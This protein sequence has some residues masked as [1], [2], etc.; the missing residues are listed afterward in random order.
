MTDNR[1][2]LRHKG[3]GKI[4]SRRDHRMK[5]LRLESQ[6]L[7][8][9]G[10]GGGLATLLLPDSHQ[11]KANLDK[12]ADTYNVCWVKPRRSSQSGLGDRKQLQLAL[13][14]DGFIV[15]L[16]VLFGEHIENKPGP[17]ATSAKAFTRWLKT[18]LKKPSSAAAKVVRADYE[19]L[20]YVERSERWWA[21]AFAH[22]KKRR[23]K[24]STS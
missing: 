11:E 24:E 5:A 15:K 19:A 12:I 6:R 20:C 18:Q 21:D 10:Q 1:L 14:D 23:V 13:A 16:L 7:T 22:R 4:A 8:E 2:V 3:T 9:V 17:Q